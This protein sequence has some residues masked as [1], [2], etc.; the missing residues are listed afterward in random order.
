MVF[1]HA[2]KQL[3][4]EQ[5]AKLDKQ[6]QLRRSASI[7]AHA[8]FEQQVRAYS[9]PRR[10]VY[11][12]VESKPYSAAMLGL[13]LLYSI[14]MAFYEPLQPDDAGAN[15]VIAQSE[16]AFT[17]VFLLDVLMQ[18]GH[19]GAKRFFTGIDRW[20]NGLDVLVVAAGL[21]AFVPG[22]D[23]SFGMLRMLRVL[24]PLRTLNRVQSVKHVVVALG[25]SIP[26]LGNVF[27]LVLFVIFIYALFGVKM[28]V[29]TLEGRCALPYGVE[30][31]S[32]GRHCDI[33]RLVDGT[34][35][36][37]VTPEGTCSDL[38]DR[39]V[40]G[41][42]TGPESG[43]CCAP[44][45]CF[46]A[47]NP[48]GGF[49]GFNN[50]GMAILTVFN[51]MTLEGWSGTVFALTQ[52]QGGVAVYIYFTT[53]M[54]L[55][56]LLVT[57]YLLA[58]CCVVFGMHMENIRLADEY[59]EQ[60][61][62]MDK[63][64]KMTDGSASTDTGDPQTDTIVYASADIEAEAGVT[65]LTD[66]EKP[67]AVAVEPARPV[68]RSCWQKVQTWRGGWGDRAAVKQIHA[69][70]Y[71]GPVEHLL[72]GAIIANFILLGLEHHE[73]DQDFAWWLGLG[74]VVLTGVFTVEMLLK[75]LSLG[76]LGY[77]KDPFNA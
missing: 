10:L 4:A 72:T 36:D 18:L 29:G 9:A 47:T 1:I 43:L 35:V 17:I 44:E 11:V 16:S 76:L 26:G 45:R 24:R 75:Q 71:S 66:K 7:S 62:T 67:P 54:V 60:K 6:Q 28:W 38:L 53:L 69:C 40:P 37:G 27:A 15:W 13:I 12:V 50:I 22:I 42:Y 33:W 58:E 49:T 57:N 61:I 64:R 73:M 14:L 3:T 48:D 77:L 8:D 59:K 65:V 55:G 5:Q 46:A 23:S 20:W 41:K 19:S 39:L 70:V 56:G 32:S 21:I 30:G 25:E 51:T 63:I 74:N 31:E 2:E 68:R 52:A 34:N